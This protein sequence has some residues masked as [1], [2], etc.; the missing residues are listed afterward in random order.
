MSQI[1]EI[2]PKITSPLAVICFSVYVFYLFKQSDDRKKAESLKVSDSE[3]QKHAVDLVLRDYPDI[4]IDPIKDPPG[5]LVLAKQIIDNKL[6]KYRKTL[7]AFLIFAS[8]F[9]VTFI[10]SLIIGPKRIFTVPSIDKS[11]TVDHSQTWAEKEAFQTGDHYALL[12]VVQHI[13]LNDI[14]MLDSTKKRSALFR[15]TYTIKALKDININDH[16]FE[17][18]FLTNAATIQPWP[19]SNFQ[20]IESIQ[21]GRY[22]VKFEAKKNEIVTVV[23]GANYLYSIPLPENGSSGCFQNLTVSKNEWF[24]CYPNDL[25]EIDDMMIII[26]AGNIELRL[27]PNSMYHKA[28]DG[29]V[30][31]SDGTCRIYS[32]NN[33]CTLVARWQ[34]ISHGECVGF[35]IDWS[36]P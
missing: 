23:T 22:W 32:S 26:E 19:G 24:T 2:I 8:I 34:N 29:A 4:S 28:K 13:I 10:I 1:W 31:T 12:S 17:E 15:T 11:D 25:D 30:T 18:Q 33:K 3:A 7:N 16:V 14:S 5:A 21:D 35:K 27:P 20:E 36:Q 9:A 6:E